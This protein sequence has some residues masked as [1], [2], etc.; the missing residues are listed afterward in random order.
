MATTLFFHNA[1]TNRQIFYLTEGSRP[2]YAMII[3]YE[4]SFS[5]SMQGKDFIIGKN[6]IGFFP[7]DIIFTRSIIKPI[8]FHQF[9]F[10]ADSDEL[11]LP[12]NDC[13][14]LNLPEEH[15][16]TVTD[17]LNTI[18][19]NEIQKSN[20]IFQN[21]IDNILMANHIYSAQKSTKTANTDKDVAFA[22]EYM[23]DHLSEKINIYELADMLHLTHTGLIGKF[24]RVHG[25]TPNEYLIK[26]RMKFAKKLISEGQL[27]INEIANICGYQNAYYFSNAFHGYFG[28]TPSEYRKSSRNP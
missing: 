9:G 24:K 19:S 1:F 16:S 21:V 8:S 12:P 6:E 4:G 23:Y 2:W 13:G 10:H 3:V 27:R 18:E 14:K 11:Y 20:R 5:F 17:M 7:K 25:C 28:M 15:V 22:V 26:M